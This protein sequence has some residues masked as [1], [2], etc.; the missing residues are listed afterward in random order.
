MRWHFLIH[1]TLALFLIAEC[2]FFSFICFLW[3]QKTKW[4]YSM[5]WQEMVQRI[6]KN[7]LIIQYKWG[8][9]STTD[10]ITQEDT[11]ITQCKWQEARKYYLHWTQNTCYVHCVHYEHCKSG[12]IWNITA[13]CCMLMT[14]ELRTIQPK[15]FLTWTQCLCYKFSQNTALITETEWIMSLMFLMNAQYRLCFYFT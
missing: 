4:T 6:T 13:F 8:L 10:L 3:G 5:T 12:M 9:I 7:C 11:H 1:I 14:V 15:H 2:R